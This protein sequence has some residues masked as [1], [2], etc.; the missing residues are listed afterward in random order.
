MKFLAVV[1]LVVCCSPVFADGWKLVWADE[2]NYAG[3][4]DP[5]KWGYE[6]GFVRNNESQYYT[7]NR[8]ENV[9][10][11]DGMLIIEARKEKFL[12]AGFLS[13]AHGREGQKVADYTSGSILTKGKFSF[14]YGRLE[15]RAKMPAGAGTWPAI[16]TL[17]TNVDTVGWPRCG[18]IDVMEFLGREGNA[19]HG[20]LHWQDNQRQPA[21]KGVS[22]PL[23]TA[24]T[25]FHI[26]AAEWSPTQIDLYVDA[27]K[28]STVMLSE[29]E[30]GHDNPFRHPQFLL[31]GLAIG[32]DWGG[33]KIDDA[34]APWKYMIDYVRLY[35]RDEGK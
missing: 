12:N 4:P 33:P 11:E 34:T 31:L 35:K 19:I 22:V 18:E 29:T 10:V 27:T 24:T 9:R 1:I 16:W 13:G 30:A 7:N 26:Y 15:V 8:L 21:Q 20:T 6:K 2:F 23:P 3:H 32:G 28:Y 17:G 5:S 25:E 14:T